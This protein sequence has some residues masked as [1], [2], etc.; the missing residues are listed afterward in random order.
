MPGQ[1]RATSTDD[2]AVVPMLNPAP[3]AANLADVNRDGPLRIVHYWKQNWRE[4]AQL[5]DHISAHLRANVV[6]L[7][8]RLNNNDPQAQGGAGGQNDEQ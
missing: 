8:A 7:R 1:T 6:L 5:S 2:D 3:A 4:L